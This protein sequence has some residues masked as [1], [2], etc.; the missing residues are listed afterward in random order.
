MVIKKNIIYI[1][2]MFYI[3]NDIKNDTK[4][5]FY[6]KKYNLYYKKM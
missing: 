5:M 4:K 6:I 2:K 3:K 1:I